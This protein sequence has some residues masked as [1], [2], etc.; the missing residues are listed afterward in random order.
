MKMKLL[1]LM[2]LSVSLI[3]VNAQFRKIP[4]VVTDSFKVRFPNAEHVNWKDKMETFQAEFKTGVD[5]VKANFSSKGEWQHTE[6]KYSYDKL[7]AEVKDGF[8]K[9]KF[10]NYSVQDVK[11]IDDVKDGHEFKLTVKK[12]NV[13]KRNLYFTAA[14]QLV[15]DSVGL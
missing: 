13:T 10:A 3:S 11:E 4:A 9:S 12:G 14:G 6:R 5:D 15:S 1:M 2:L 8:K 7:P